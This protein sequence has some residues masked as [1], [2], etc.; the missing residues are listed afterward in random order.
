MG[1]ARERSDCSMWFDFIED[2]GTVDVRIVVFL[3]SV[4]H[5]PHIHRKWI[6]IDCSLRFC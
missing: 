4:L 3:V 2:G 1:S 5:A 6:E